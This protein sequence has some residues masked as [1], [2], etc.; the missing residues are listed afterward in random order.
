[1]N[2]VQEREAE[3]KREYTINMWWIRIANFWETLGKV[4]SLQRD[5]EYYQNE[6]NK[7]RSQYIRKG[8]KLGYSPKKAA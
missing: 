8:R 6:L 7:I 5:M 2:Y 4:M 3:L 1:M